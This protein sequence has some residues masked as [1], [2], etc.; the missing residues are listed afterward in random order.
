MSVAQMPTDRPWEFGVLQD[1][2]FLGFRSIAHL[3]RT[4][5]LEVPVEPG[6][7]VVVRESERPPEFLAQ[8]A[9]GRFRGKDPTVTVDVLKEKWVEGAQVLYIGGAPGPG[10]RSLLQQRV[11]RHI[12]FG[13]GKAIAHAGGRFIWQLRDQMALKVAWLPAPGGDVAAEEAN[14][15]FFFS[16]YHGR[17]PFANEG[18][19]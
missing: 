9:A 8:S 7:Y 13:M 18:R 16:A 17:L 2:G 11:K 15:L 4:G 14:Y 10:V 5:C 12:R 1:A 3:H 6:V 19:E